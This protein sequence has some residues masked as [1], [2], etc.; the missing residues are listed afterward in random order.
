MIVAIT[1]TPGTGKSMVREQLQNEGYRVLDLNDIILIKKLVLSYDTHRQT[2]EVD[3]EGLNNYIF[4][5]IKKIS[6]KGLKNDLIFLE[7]HISHLLDNID[8]VIILR[9]HPDELHRRLSAKGWHDEKV[10]ENLE[11]EAVDSITIESMEKYNQNKIFEI[12][13]TH[14][15]PN[16]ISKKI[17]E[18]VNGKTEGYAPGKI[19]WSEEILKWY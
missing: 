12:N 4:E 17:L 13:T 18:I 10:R 3:L 15:K 6:K 19:D 16:I 1:G 14:D 8:L 2:N 11:A 7:G 9:C 5:L